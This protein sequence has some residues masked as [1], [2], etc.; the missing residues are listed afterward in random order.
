MKDKSSESVRK[1]LAAPPGWRD[2]FAN[3]FSRFKG[4]SRSRR[5]RSGTVEQPLCRAAA[6]ILNRHVHAN[7]LAPRSVDGAT[8]KS[9]YEKVV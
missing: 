7:G 5:V 3:R 4:A 2:T 1:N 6:G 9:E 8:C